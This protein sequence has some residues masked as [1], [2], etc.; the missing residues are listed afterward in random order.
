MLQVIA[1]NALDAALRE[2]VPAFERQSGSEVSVSYRS[3][4]QIL[5]RVRSGESADLL[6]AG[7][8]AIDELVA[9]GKVV[10]GSRTD[11]AASGIAVCVKSGAPRPDIGTVEAFKRALLAASSIAHTATGQSGSYFAGLVDRL[12]IGEAV[13]AKA[14]VSAGGIIGELV[15]RGEAE[16][17]IQQASEVLAVPGVE[18]VGPLPAE[19]QKVTVFAAGVCSG[20]RDADTARALVEFLATASSAAV[21]RAKGLDPAEH[22]KFP[23]E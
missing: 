3:T 6:I 7:R 14:K 10:P 12:G 8:A 17:G 5:E 13:R 20:A 19:I 9:A 21:M 11:L 16:L 1:S 4:N 22:G 18:L 2:L 23:S 15:T